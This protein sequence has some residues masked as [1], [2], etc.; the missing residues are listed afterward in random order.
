LNLRLNTLL[1]MQT[2][3]LILLILQANLTNSL[4]Q[5]HKLLLRLLNQQ[6]Q[7]PQIIT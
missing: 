3:S 5:M 6:L 4:L 2:L 1:H 7:L